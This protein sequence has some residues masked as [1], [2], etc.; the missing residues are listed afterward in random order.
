MLKR[1][2]AEG[3][4]STVSVRPTVIQNPIIWG[5]DGSA[6]LSD[7]I[8]LALN[9]RHGD[10]LIATPLDEGGLEIRKSTTMRHIVKSY[11]IRLWAKLAI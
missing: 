9:A 4:I 3:S 8:I 6:G 1:N 11:A 7:E 10:T 5:E 2:S